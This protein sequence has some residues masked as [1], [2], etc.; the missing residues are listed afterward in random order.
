MAVLLG[1]ESYGLFLIGFKRIFFNAA[2]RAYPV[3][4]K[5]F[6]RSTRFYPVV[7]VTGFWVIDIAAYRTNIFFHDRLLL[8]ISDH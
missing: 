7:R 2:D 1:V 4:R 3:V 6:E 5:V 8:S